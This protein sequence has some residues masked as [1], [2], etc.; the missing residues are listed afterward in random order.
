MKSHLERILY[1]I[2]YYVSPIMLLTSLVTLG[3]DDAPTKS[4]L[5]S[6]TMPSKEAIDWFKQRFAD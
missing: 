2:R 4:G 1:H 5:L 3:A 6:D